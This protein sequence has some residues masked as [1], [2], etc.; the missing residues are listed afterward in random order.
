MRSRLR[1]VRDRWDGDH[2]LYHSLILMGVGH[3]GSVANLLFHLLMGRTC[4]RAEYGVLAAMLSAFLVFSVPLMALQS[5]LAHFCGRLE[6]EGREHEIRRLLQSWLKRVLLVAGPLLLLLLLAGGPIRRAL[7]LDSALPVALLAAVLFVAAFRPVLSG[8][9]QGLQHFFW[10]SVTVN[11]WTFLRLLFG[12]IAVGLGFATAAGGLTAHLLGMVAC[13]AIG[14]AVLARRLPAPAGD[15]GKPVATNRY[16]LLSLAALF[17]YAL[18]MNGDNVLV[19]LFFPAEIDFGDYARASAVARIIVFL[20]QPVGFALFPKVISTGASAAADRK[21]LFKALAL[22]G[23][24]IAGV[25]AAV[26]LFPAVPLRI[27]FGVIDPAPGLVQLLRGVCVAMAP[28]GLIFVLLNYELAQHRFACILWVGGAAAVFIAG[29][30][31]FHETT[32]QVAMA[33]AAST[34]GA[35]AGLVMLLTRREA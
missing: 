10:M 1:R 17:G 29:V 33:L 11:A 16:F 9:L 15:P 5:T 35:L 24:L 23:L 31:L 3:A 22:T 19:K 30:A 25:V 13:I 20:C 27:L 26:T 28:L 6:K 21:T 7:Y 32:G 14:G 12:G 8:V 34:Y 2:L 18:L 4:S